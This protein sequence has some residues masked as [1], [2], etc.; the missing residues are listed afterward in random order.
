ML[1]CA[2]LRPHEDGESYR[3]TFPDFPDCVTGADTLCE[4]YGM[5]EEA[6]TEHVRECIAKGEPLPET[7][8]PE[9]IAGLGEPGMALI[10]VPVRLET[11]RM[12]KFTVTMPEQERDLLDRMAADWGM[13]RSQFVV[14]AVRE[15]ADRM[16]CL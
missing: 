10:M 2:L 12:V 14:A 8:P 9:Q 13:S 15:V 11:R 3:V 7:T 5:A 16:G 6:L 4:A 1:Y